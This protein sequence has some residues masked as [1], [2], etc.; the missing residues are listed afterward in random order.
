MAA[1]FDWLARIPTALRRPVR[2]MLRRRGFMTWSVETRARLI[3]S[4]RLIV[5]PALYN[6]KRDD[7]YD[8]VEWFT[9]MNASHLGSAR[10]TQDVLL[11]RGEDDSFQPPALTRAQ[12]HT[13][14]A[15]RS[16]TIRSFTAG[17][18]ADQH[19]QM[20]LALACSVLTGWL[21]DATT[22]GPR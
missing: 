8:V 6:L 7:P 3:P 21:H 12:A 4:L 5:D 16:V 9:G 1:V 19:G 17:E 20:G 14:T 22:L 10:A 18:H 15:A 13:L 11:L 2:A